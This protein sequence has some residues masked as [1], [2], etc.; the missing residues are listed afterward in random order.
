MFQMTPEIEDLIDRALTEDL[1]IGDPTSEVLL[2]P[3]LTGKG[4]VKAKAEG[5]LAGVDVALAVFRRVDPTLETKALLED[6]TAL[7]AGDVIA[8]ATGP[9]SSIL[10][11][12]RT[13]LNFLQHLSGIATATDKYVQAVKG[14]RARIIDTR[15]TT[16]GLRTLEKYAIRAGGGHNHRRN[17]GDGILIKDNHI[18][19]LRNQGLSLAEIV[20]KA[21]D[22]A[23]HTIRIEVEVEDLDQVCEALDAGADILML[24]NMGLSEM[25][26]AVSLVGGRAV[27][28]ASGGINLETVRDVAATGVDLIS[29]GA[30]THS[31]AALDISLDL[32]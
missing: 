7:H 31:V 30:L 12:E 13:A 25:A 19:A 20:N 9:V 5:I 28:E 23:S 18:Q 24:D 4:E 3:E 15:K 11:A 8:H 2:S 6:G 17:L 14:H 10:R 26:D 27:I 1:S 22:G 21:R 29:A 16:P 32:Q